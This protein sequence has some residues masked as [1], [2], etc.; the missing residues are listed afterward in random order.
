M[1]VDPVEYGTKRG[2][3][4]DDCTNCTK[5]LIGSIKPYQKHLI[6]CAQGIPTSWMSEIKDAGVPERLNQAIVACK[7]KYILTATDYVPAGAGVDEGSIHVIV[8]PNA[9]L[10]SLPRDTVDFMPFVRELMTNETSS[11]I[12]RSPLPWSTVVL[13]CCHQARDNRCGRAGPQVMEE[14]KEQLAQRA[15]PDTTVAVLPTSHIGGHKFAGVLV[16]YPQGGWVGMGVRCCVVLCY[17]VCAVL[18][19]A[20]LCCAVLCCAVL[21]CAVLCCAV[22]CC[23]VRCGAVR[24]GAVLCCAV[25][26]YAVQC[27][28][29]LR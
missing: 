20:V 21:C 27:G 22:L 19:C 10:F 7:V 28:A 8:Y 26:R 29:S 24:R 4:P 17:V 11:T 23:A 13:V 12:S 18:C 6:L 16:V 25:L 2:L 3:T 5:S 1:P 15:I 9:Q 14:L